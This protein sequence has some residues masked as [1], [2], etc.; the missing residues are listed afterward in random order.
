MTSYYTAFAKKAQGGISERA[1]RAIMGG[2]PPLEY[3][4]AP[5][6]SGLDWAD[7][8]ANADGVEDFDYSA[9]PE[10]PVPPSASS[11]TSIS[12]SPTNHSTTLPVS[13]EPQS[14]SIIRI[15]SST[16]KDET[17]DP[18]SE[19]LIEIQTM[20][21]NPWAEEIPVIR[22]PSESELSSRNTQRI[23]KCPFTDGH[24]GSTFGQEENFWDAE[25]SWDAIEPTW[26]VVDDPLPL[27]SMSF[28]VHLVTAFSICYRVGCFADPDS[29]M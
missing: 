14:A 21:D 4:T 13:P 27:P 26:D 17:V 19:S 15:I 1:M 16:S 24:G 12:T 11:V 8:V 20:P 25:P 6:R 3:S 2:P 22:L 5:E 7:V 10:F 9:L 18:S 29:R 23:T 28:K